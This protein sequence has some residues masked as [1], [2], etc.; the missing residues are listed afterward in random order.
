MLLCGMRQMGSFFVVQ[1][2]QMN[3]W[4][5]GGRF[6]VRLEALLQFSLDFSDQYWPCQPWD[7]YRRFFFN[8]KANV[9]SSPIY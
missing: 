7:F 8:A 9:H 5:F 3:R 2:A 4:L 6:K 1:G